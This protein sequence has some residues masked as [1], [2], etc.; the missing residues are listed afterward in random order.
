M[1]SNCGNGETTALDNIQYTEAFLFDA[2][3][4]MF[5]IVYLPSSFDKNSESAFL[6]SWTILAPIS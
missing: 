2:V 1:S 5:S 3:D 4:N 6:I